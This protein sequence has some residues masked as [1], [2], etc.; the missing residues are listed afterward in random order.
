VQDV[1]DFLP[2]LR[3]EKVVAN[4]VAEVAVD[5][6]VKVVEIGLDVP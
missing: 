2:E 1:V 4:V 3:K 5:V 6:A